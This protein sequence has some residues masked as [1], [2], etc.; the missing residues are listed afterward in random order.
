[1]AIPPAAPQEPAEP[2]T[3]KAPAQ[4]A[5]VTLPKTTAP[6]R[7]AVATAVS[8]IVAGFQCAD[9]DA[10]LSAD[11]KVFISGRLSSSRDQRML[12]SR[13]G[14]LEHVRGV[15]PQVEIVEHPFCDVLDL[16]G[17]HGLA[18]GHSGR[19]GPAI[20]VNSPTR[21]FREG[22]HLVVEVT[23]GREERGH[24]YVA[25]MDSTGTFVHMLPT[26][27]RA[28]TAVSPGQRVVLGAAAGAEDP[29][30][31]HY[32]ITPPHGRGLIVALLSRQPLFDRPR[33][34]IEPAADL[35]DAL[36]AQLA[37]L[38]EAGRTADVVASALFIETRP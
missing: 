9:L 11:M 20:A 12:E 5:V 17:P 10:T 30:I 37:K 25:Y 38:R 35:L 1:V 14:A 24:L 6:D 22:E 31:R 8:G 19:K 28:A 34:E 23:A 27:L 3:A 2:P 4:V 26:P 29:G 33:P 13:L 15:V 32:E 36:D 16:L 7:A 18:T 21:T